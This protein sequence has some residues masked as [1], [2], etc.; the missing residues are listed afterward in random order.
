MLS[1]SAGERIGI[2]VRA[3]VG[4]SSP[5]FVN[6]NV[7]T[8]LGCAATVKVQLYWWVVI[9]PISLAT[10]HNVSYRFCEPPHEKVELRIG[11]GM[12]YAGSGVSVL[13]VRCHPQ[14]ME[15]FR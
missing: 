2:K 3:L 8:L 15:Q 1:A 9:L 11:E 12:P 13:C 10:V 7:A 6:I 14:L 5:T 4:I